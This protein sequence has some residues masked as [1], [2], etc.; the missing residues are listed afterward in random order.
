MVNRKNT[1]PQGTNSIAG[2]NATGTGNRTN[3]ATLKGSN[4]CS[5][6]SGSACAFIPH[7]WAVPTAMKFNRCAVGSLLVLPLRNPSRRP[8][9]A[10]G[11]HLLLERLQIDF[12]QLPQLCEHPFE[13]GRR[14]CILIDL[15]LRGTLR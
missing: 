14:V 3:H 1:C 9:R 10:G 5:I 12:D 11:F 2:G 8:G 13:L 7:P 4:Q 6:P 15:R